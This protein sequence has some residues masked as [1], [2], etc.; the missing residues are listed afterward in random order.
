MQ[1][2]LWKGNIACFRFRVAG[3][4]APLKAL[5]VRYALFEYFVDIRNSLKGRLPRKLFLAKARLLH[6]AWKQSM[7]D[8][9][10]EVGKT[11]NFT[12]RWL[13]GWCK[14]FNVSMKHPNKRFKL[15]ADERRTRILR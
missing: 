4:G 13:Q 6:E 5:E 14:Q 12:R 3:A 7:V 10:K 8:Q 9:G 11:M 1:S 15:N 2:V